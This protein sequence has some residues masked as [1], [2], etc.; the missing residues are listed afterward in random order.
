MRNELA[1]LD[2]SLSKATGFACSHRPSFCKTPLLYRKPPSNLGTEWET[3]RTRTTAAPG[4]PDPFW[5]ETV[6]TCVTA[7]SFTAFYYMRNWV[8]TVST[9]NFHLI[10][11]H[12]INTFTFGPPAMILSCWAKHFPQKMD[13]D[14]ANFAAGMKRR[15]VKHS[16]VSVCFESF[17]LQQNILKISVHVNDICSWK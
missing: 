10:A 15:N 1:S 3:W 8:W 7:D 17:K 5:G 11:F 13:F 14:V 6:I 4:V 12:Y 2:C 16:I 9:L